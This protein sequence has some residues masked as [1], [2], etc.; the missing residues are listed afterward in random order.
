[1]ETVRY[2]YRLRPGANALAYL[3]AEWGRCRWLWNEC[4]HQF[5]T[6]RKPTVS[7]LSKLLTAERARSEWLRAGSQN[8]Q[9]QMLRTYM[10]ALGDSFTVE[11]RQRPKVKKRKKTLPSLEYTVNGF[12]LEGG[13]LCLPKG[14]SIPVVW[15]RSLPSAPSSVRVFRDSLG[16][17]Y[18]SFV[19]VREG[20]EPLP[21]VDGGVGIDWGVATTA[22]A[23]DERYDLPFGGHRKR[24]QAELAKAQRKM[25]R[26][27]RPKGQKASKGYADAKHQAARLLKKATRQN[28]AAARVWAAAVVSGNDVIGV[29]DFK[30]RFLAK[31]KNM[32]GK[33]ADAAIGATKRELVQRGRRAGRKVVMVP[34]AYTTMTCSECFARAKRRLEL[35][36]RAFRCWFCGYTAERDRNSARVVL[37]LARRILDTEE[38]SRAGVD[39]VSHFPAP[40]EGASVVLPEP[41]IPRL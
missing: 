2:N 8:A 12:A 11:G 24:C 36:E 19:V 5:R 20:A 34:P 29:E 17:W 1:M 3:L 14:V 15:S 10:K 22:T 35:G 26:R 21:D 38:L 41:E 7:K 39:G 33:A 18:A 28:T 23:S 6:R 37:A 31:S 13:R 16:H 25:A 40:F 32:A 4:V 27:K 9:Q 30:P